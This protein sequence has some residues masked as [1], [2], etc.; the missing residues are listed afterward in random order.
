[1]TMRR[2]AVLLL[3]LCSNKDFFKCVI[4]NTDLEDKGMSISDTY[5]FFSNCSISSTFA[6]N[7]LST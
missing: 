7:A 6:L 1:M 4:S 2:L 3:K 5:A